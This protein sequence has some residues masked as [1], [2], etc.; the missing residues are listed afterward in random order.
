MGS[1]VPCW[2]S[3]L[4]PFLIRPRLEL[5]RGKILVVTANFITMLGEARG[6]GLTAV[7]TDVTRVE[8]SLSGVS[9][10]VFIVPTK[11]KVT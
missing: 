1:I 4:Y 9:F 6:Q 3:R 10:S 11:T 5:L 8:C 2:T 7:F